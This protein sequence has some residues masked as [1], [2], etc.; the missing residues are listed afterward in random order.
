MLRARSELGYTRS[1]VAL[2]SEVE[3]AP[4]CVNL[5]LGFLSRCIGLLLIDSVSAVSESARK[6]CR[7]PDCIANVRLLLRCICFKLLPIDSFKLLRR[8]GMGGGGLPARAVQAD[9]RLL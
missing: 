9:C 2:E 5:R 7:I 8:C 3:W 4:A 6:P 1:K